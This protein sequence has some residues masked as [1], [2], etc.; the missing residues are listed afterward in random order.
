[1][2][3]RR[4]TILLLGLSLSAGALPLAAQ[5]G[6]SEAHRAAQAKLDDAVE[7]LR[8]LR[9]E[10]GA[11][12]VPLSAERESLFTR[13]QGIRREADRAQRL[14]DNQGSD[15]SSLEANNAAQAEVTDYLINLSAEFG[16]SLEAQ[17]EVSE[18]GRYRELVSRAESASDDPYLTPLEKLE[19]QLAVIEAALD[20]AEALVGGAAY[21][22]QAIMPGGLFEEGTFARFGP[23]VYFA[24]KSGAAGLSQQGQST[25]PM[26]VPILG[27][28]L[29]PAIVSL[30]RGELANVPSDPTLGN[31]LAIA[32]TKESLLDHVDK[33][34]LWVWPILGFAGLSL[35]VGLFKAFELYTLPSPKDG[36]LAKIL[37][38]L[39]SGETEAAVAVANQAPGPIGRMLQQGVRY[40]KHDPEL[41]EEILYETVVET[42]PK[43][44][45]LL[46]FI[47]VTAAVAPLLGLLGTVTGMI[48][49]F[50]LIEVFGAGDAKKLSGGI[51]EALITTEFGLIVAIPALLIYAIL[52][53]KARAFLGRME[54]QSISF[55]NGLK[56]MQGREEMVPLEG[57]AEPAKEA[58]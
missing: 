31:A 52:S 7:R 8:T 13:L 47:S 45:R 36:T 40:S 28:R 24:S 9:D 34:G 56:A 10:I 46:P 4:P 3:F 57:K 18:R 38:H 30:A 15:L 50:R 41:V 37:G 11:E 14:R 29:D 6:L 51:S 17:L 2:R 32:A 49:T 33:G 5:A 48:N 12:K 20:R 42:Q 21:P 1:M 26:V 53:R 23:L 16:R 25:D 58:V 39:D 19:P 54:K 44:Q 27:G 55:V 43:V 22:G 35:I